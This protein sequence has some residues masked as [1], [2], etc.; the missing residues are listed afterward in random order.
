METLNVNWFE[1]VVKFLILV[2]GDTNVSLT[3]WA[4]VF[5]KLAF[6]LIVQYMQQQRIWE[7]DAVK[8]WKKYHQIP[9]P[10]PPPAF[11]HTYTIPRFPRL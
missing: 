9:P 2:K 3:A 4:D 8:Y 5:P 1:I 6:L 7:V 11:N 10:P